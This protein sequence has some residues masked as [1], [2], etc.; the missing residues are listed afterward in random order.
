MTDIIIAYATIAA[1]LEA[2]RRS[3]PL[4]ARAFADYVPKLVP[5]IAADDLA[6]AIPAV[7]EEFLIERCTLGA[8]AALAYLAR[9]LTLKPTDRLGHDTTQSRSATQTKSPA[10]PRRK[11]Q[12]VLVA[13]TGFC[14]DTAASRLAHA[15]VPEAVIDVTNIGNIGNSMRVKTSL[16]RFAARS[17]A[18][19]FQTALA[20]CFS[21][22]LLSPHS[23]INSRDTWSETFSNC[24]TWGDPIQRES[25]KP[26]VYYNDTNTDGDTFLY[27]CPKPKSALAAKGVPDQSWEDVAG[28][29]WDTISGTGKSKPLTG[30]KDNGSVSDT[31]DDKSGAKRKGY[32]GD[33]LVPHSGPQLKGY[34]GI[35]DIKGDYGFGHLQGGSG[36]MPGVP[37]GSNLQQW[38]GGERTKDTVDFVWGG[39]SKEKVFNWTDGT[40]EQMLNWSGGTVAPDTTLWSGGTFDCNSTKC[41]R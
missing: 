22:V 36:T 25:Y 28:E 35:D 18:G 41:A 38:Y 16:P 9:N 14:D 21:F 8:D 15:D 23:M 40:K 10:Y 2:L 17:T 33:T 37:L 11:P 30:W 6:E 3:D 20:A 4:S 1:R 12:F 39:A 13:G 32:T 29:S 26:K 24:D 34:S 27:R 19:L 7:F 5:Q 31:P